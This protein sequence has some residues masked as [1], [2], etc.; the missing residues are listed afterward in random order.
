[1]NN[2]VEVPDEIPPFTCPKISLNEFYT[3]MSR[4][5]VD[6]ATTKIIHDNDLAAEA[7]DQID[8]M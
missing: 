6:S 5:V 8:K 1:M 3:P 4:Q 2:G 7:D